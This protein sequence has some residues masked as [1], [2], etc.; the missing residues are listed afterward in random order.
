M[1]NSIVNDKMPSVFK[2]QFRSLKCGEVPKR[3]GQT[4][5]YEATSEFRETFPQTLEEIS[6]LHVSVKIDGTCTRH[7]VCTETGRVQFFKRYDL[8]NKKKNRKMPNN[9][10]SGFVSANQ[11]APNI[12][13]LNITESTKSEDKFH[14]SAIDDNGFWTINSN[15]HPEMVPFEKAIDATYE[16]IGPKIQSNLYNIKSVETSVKIMKKGKLVDA[17]VPR[18]Y[19]VLHGVFSIKNFPFNKFFHTKD[20]VDW[21]RQYIVENQ[22]EG[23]VFRLDSQ[24]N[25]QPQSF[26]KVNRGHIGV[27]YGKAESLNLKILV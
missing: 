4:T 20:R 21:I 14:L 13:W 18:H 24:K 10:V 16:L 27:C 22:I 5:I 6:K 2:T 17:R 19:Y 11:R 8:H 26:W 3:R 25:G 12:C 23:L 1:S 15:G 7:I 9:A